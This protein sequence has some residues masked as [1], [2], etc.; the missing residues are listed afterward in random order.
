MWFPR[1]TRLCLRK[2]P[3]FPFVCLVVAT[4]VHR[5]IIQNL[6]YAELRVHFIGIC[7]VRIF[8]RSAKVRFD[9]ALRV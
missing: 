6:T 3:R 8:R 4:N 1:S 2:K 5:H 9:Y 7:F